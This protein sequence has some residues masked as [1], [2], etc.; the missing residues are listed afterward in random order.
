MLEEILPVLNNFRD[1]MYNFF[2][3]RKDATMELVDS[4]SSNKKAASVVELSLSP[5]KL[6]TLP[7]LSTQLL[8]H[9]SGSG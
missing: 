4:L 8:Q 5:L 2:H 1:K 3:H 9:Y 6:T 7:F